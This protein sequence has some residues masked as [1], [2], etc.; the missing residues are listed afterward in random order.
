VFHVA[1]AE[2]QILH[3]HLRE[4]VAIDVRSTSPARAA[5]QPG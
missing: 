2:L 5:A 1:L 3:A 4:D